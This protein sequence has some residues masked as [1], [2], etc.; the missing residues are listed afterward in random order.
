MY[1]L[2]LGLLTLLPGH[3]FACDR[4]NDISPDQVRRDSATLAD[5]TAS[6][7]ER[8][9]AFETL[10]CSQSAAIRDLAF[11]SARASGLPPLQAQALFD[12]L[13]SKPLISIDLL[14]ND[15]LTE[16]HYD[17][18]DASPTIVLKSAGA[19]DG[20]SC[21]SLSRPDECNTSYAITLVGTNMDFFENG[22]GTGTFQLDADGKLSGTV[23]LKK[24]ELTFPAEIVLD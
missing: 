9:L 23:T 24:P 10:R 17:Y 16:Q 20:Q 14:S 3:L 5:P 6:E 11:R 21:I 2:L 12:R 13:S 1:R 19:V 4:L 18:L 15:G 22:L 7:I 8:I